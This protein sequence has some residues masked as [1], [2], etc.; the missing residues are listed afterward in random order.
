MTIPSARSLQSVLL[1]SAIT[2]VFSSCLKDD[3]TQFYTYRLFKP[4]YLPYE[5]LRKAVHTLPA[6]PLREVGKIYYLPPYILVNEID[7]GIHI[8]DN[9]NPSSPQNIA[10][11]HIPGNLDIAVKDHILYA[12]SYVD[13]VAIDISDPLS[14]K[15]VW[16]DHNQFEQRSYNGWTGDN[17]KGVIID[18]IESDSTIESTCSPM[19][20]WT[21][22]E[23]AVGINTGSAG[24]STTSSTSP[25]LG[26]AGS[27]ARFAIAKDYLYCL[28]TSSINLYDVSIATQPVG[29]G[30]VFAGWGIETLFPYENKLFV[31]T[32]TGVS[33]FDNIVPSAPTLL[34]TVTH[35]TG[36]DPVVVQGDFAFSTVH[37]GNFCGQIFN[38]L[39]VIDVSN[40]ESP[41]ISRTY[42]LFKPYGLGIDGEH[43]FICDDQQGLKMYNASDPV[44]LVLKQETP[45]GTTRDVIALGGWL[46]LVSLEGIYQF[47]YSEGELRQLSFLP[48]AR[49]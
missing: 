47:D 6:T 33:I 39:N 29:Q 12:D 10:F 32:T 44:N 9:S 34:S 1:L 46:L 41:S 37:S 5:E 27:L 8:I 20:S 18:W 42:S 16:R 2:M 30:S 45:A 3:C 35:V 43:L 31:G 7:E 28:N 19:S 17:A 25:G 13:L 15:E 11:I 24:G 23:T 40:P 26:V 49:E 36:C 21:F 4:V 48:I 14:A 22:F 38:E